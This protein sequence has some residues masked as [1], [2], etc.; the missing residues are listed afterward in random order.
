MAFE[1][2]DLTGKR[3]LVTGSSQGIGLAIAQGLAE[4]V[5]LFVFVEIQLAG[6]S[7][8]LGRPVRIGFEV[9]NDSGLQLFR[10]SFFLCGLA[11]PIDLIGRIR[12]QLEV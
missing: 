9:F 7:A 5:V 6:E 1:L 12:S 4:R 3:A 2:F 10:H 8:R 11:H